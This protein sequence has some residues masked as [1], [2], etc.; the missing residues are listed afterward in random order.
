MYPPRATSEPRVPVKSIPGYYMSME[1]PAIDSLTVD[2]QSPLIVNTSKV[3]VEKLVREIID[4]EP[5]DVADLVTTGPS[6]SYANVQHIRA[7][8]HI[9]ALKLASG[10]KAV[11]VAH[12]LHLTQQTVCRLQQDPQF[13]DLVEHYRGEL[14]TKALGA[15]E[16]M[17]LVTME[18]LT[19]LHERLIGDGRDDIPF[20][21]LRRVGETFTDRTGHSPI[22]RSES[23]NVNASGQ[24]SDLALERIKKLNPQDARYIQSNPQQA[25]LEAVHQAEAKDQGAETSIAAIFKSVESTKAELPPSEGPSV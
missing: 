16:L 14:V 3:A 15:F 21:A 5:Q 8:H 17:E 18:S 2:A 19:A 10:E 25:A 24:I 1:L 22:R 7:Y 20:E 4:L 6:R 11:S 13:K 9:A 12:A 23:L